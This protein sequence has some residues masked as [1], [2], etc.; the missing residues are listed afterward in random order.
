MQEIPVLP[1]PVRARDDDLDVPRVG[2]DGKFVLLRV[3]AGTGPAVVAACMAVPSGVGAAA[4]EDGGGTGGGRGRAGDRGRGGGWEVGEGGRAGVVVGD[5]GWLWTLLLLVVW[6]FLLAPAACLDRSVSALLLV[7]VEGIVFTASPHAHSLSCSPVS[8]PCS[9][10]EVKYAARS[11]STVFQSVSS[12]APRHAP[13]KIRRQAIF[14]P[15]SIHT[16]SV[17]HR[18]KKRSIARGGPET[19]DLLAANQGRCGRESWSLNIAER[20]ILSKKL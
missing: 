17:S 19:G 9:S 5:H 3:P 15:A 20:E 4:G 10:S 14:P 11:P 1:P 16:S 7:V 12:T 2:E 8:Q 18:R 13:A 6:C